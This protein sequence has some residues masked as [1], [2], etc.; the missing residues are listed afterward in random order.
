MKE[1][2]AIIDSLNTSLRDCERKCK[3]LEDELEAMNRSLNSVKADKK[4]SVF[5]LQGVQREKTRLM[6]EKTELTGGSL[7]SKQAANAKGKGKDQGNAGSLA[8]TVVETSEG[9]QITKEM[10][11][12]I[13]GA[14]EKVKK[15]DEQQNN[16][17]DFVVKEL[18]KL[19]NMLKQLAECY[20]LMRGGETDLGAEIEEVRALYRKEM[21]QRKLLYNQLQEL[22]GNIRVFCRIKPDKSSCLTV[23]D[24]SISLVNV[25]GKKMEFEF[26]KIYDQKV[27]QSDIFENTKPIITSAVDGYNVCIIA[28]GQTGS[29]KSHCINFFPL[30]PL[31][32]PANNFRNPYSKT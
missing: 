5:Q 3:G 17:K 15:M 11:L 14:N 30:R 16:L 20:Q 21:L 27:S 26:D 7:K 6:R 18:E 25:H 1:K 10:E 4:N 23:S 32:F 9:P 19:K 29:G 24:E 8:S 13:K 2:D 22:R 12:M 31:F 28:Y